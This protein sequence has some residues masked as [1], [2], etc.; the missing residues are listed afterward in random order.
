ML[1]SLAPADLNGELA[2]LVFQA[3]TDADNCKL[4]AGILPFF[5]LSIVLKQRRYVTLVSHA[6][7]PLC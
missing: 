5:I 1:T 2:Y 6:L 4:C 3:N 7:E